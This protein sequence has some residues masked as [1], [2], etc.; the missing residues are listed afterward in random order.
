M[1]S[2]DQAISIEVRGEGGHVDRRKAESLGLIAAGLVINSLKHAFG[3]A[4]KGGLIVV[5]CDAVKAEWTL[6][7][8]DN[9]KGKHKQAGV[10]QGGLGTGIV[11][12]LASQLN[13]SVAT[14]SSPRG[15]SV[16]IAHH[17]A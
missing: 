4:T 15:T 12:A 7:V 13:A 2:D 5:T 10:A 6:S 9:G 14:E 3:N 17:T 16:S 8:S 11:T 1:I